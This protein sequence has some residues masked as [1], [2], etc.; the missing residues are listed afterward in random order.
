MGNW[1][2]EAG[3][4]QLGNR[5]QE[6][7]EA[8]AT[9]ASACPLPSASCMESPVADDTVF[10]SQHHVSPDSTQ[11]LADGTS[12]GGLVASPEA[13]GRWLHDAAVASASM[14][15]RAGCALTSYDCNAIM[16]RGGYAGEDDNLPD[17][18]IAQE[19][20]VDAVRKVISA[21]TLEEFTTPIV[22]SVIPR[23]EAGEG[24]DCYRGT[25]PRW[26]HLGITS[27]EMFGRQLLASA[28]Q[29]KRPQESFWI[30]PSS[31]LLI[32]RDIFSTLLDK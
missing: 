7:L 19:L 28:I 2:R 27:W 3:A 8:A 24:P 32:Q 16:G 14:V 25:V 12:R 29:V 1:G 9:T 18:I 15:N 6:A 4:A 20:C 11:A 22:L 30:R 31:G 26:I 21:V 17:F 13:D 10:S 5:L 23:H